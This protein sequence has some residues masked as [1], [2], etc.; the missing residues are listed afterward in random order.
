MIRVFG[1]LFEVT[2]LGRV[3]LG[4]LLI[5]LDDIGAQNARL[6]TKTWQ[7]E[8]QSVLC[9]PL[10]VNFSEFQ[11]IID[12]KSRLWWHQSLPTRYQSD[13]TLFVLA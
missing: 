7:N 10:F 3:L 12:K 8:G 4:T 5:I 6:A 13:L 1:P 2:E 9:K 11:I